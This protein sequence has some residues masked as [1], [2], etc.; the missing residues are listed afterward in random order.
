M[1]IHIHSQINLKKGVQQKESDEV[2]SVQSK[3]FSYQ[4][5][6]SLGW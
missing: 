1:D 3:Y 4:V 5:Q 6:T 2:E